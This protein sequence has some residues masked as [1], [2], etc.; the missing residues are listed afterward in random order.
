M[1]N[2]RQTIPERP[3]RYSHPVVTGFIKWFQSAHWKPDAA[4]FKKKKD[5][6]ENQTPLVSMEWLP[7]METNVTPSNKRR[8]K[9]P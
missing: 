9:C 1:K 7:K 5:W 2:C 4:M 8:F 3:V 6:T